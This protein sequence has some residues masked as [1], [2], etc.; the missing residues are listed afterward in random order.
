M[1]DSRDGGA[2]ERNDVIFSNEGIWECTFVGEC[3]EVCP[4]NVD[5]AGAIQMATWVAEGKI[6]F[7]EHVDQ[8]IENAITSFNRLFDGSHAGKLILQIAP[9]TLYGRLS[10]D[11]THL[12]PASHQRAPL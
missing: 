9:E 6:T 12:T 10:G 7:K 3:S 2:E 5:P 8:G 4:K 1:V 11:D